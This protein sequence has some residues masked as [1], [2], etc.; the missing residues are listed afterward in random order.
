MQR[1]TRET[2]PVSIG[3][4]PTCGLW[5]A[6]DFEDALEQLESICAH[7]GYRRRDVCI[8]Q[9]GASSPMFWVSQPNGQGGI[10]C[11]S[12][13]E[14]ISLRRRLTSGNWPQY[15]RIRKDGVRKDLSKAEAK[16][17]LEDAATSFGQIAEL[18]DS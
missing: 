11:G 1:A 5:L 15:S 13:D 6:A 17:I 16:R 18:L 10:A 4:Q 12:L 9:R 8:W 14:A 3:R 7:T 2:H